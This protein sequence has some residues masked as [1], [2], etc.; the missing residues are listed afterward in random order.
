[1]FACF[2]DIISNLEYLV[3]LLQAMVIGGDKEGRDV[4]RI[5]FGFKR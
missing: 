3:K 1:M 5:C 2:K 4:V